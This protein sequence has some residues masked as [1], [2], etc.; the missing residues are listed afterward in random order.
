MPFRAEYDHPC[1]VS[2]FRRKPVESI[3]DEYKEYNDWSHFN[4]DSNIQNIMASGMP[5]KPSDE[6]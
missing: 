5:H 4:R 6:H 2:K 3:N 1:V